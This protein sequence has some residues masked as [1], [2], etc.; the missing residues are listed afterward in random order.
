[1]A[2]VTAETQRWVLLAVMTL[3]EIHELTDFPS[4]QPI[5]RHEMPDILKQ[6]VAREVRMAMLRMAA[7]ARAAEVQEEAAAEGTEEGHALPDHIRRQLK[8]YEPTAEELASEKAQ[9]AKAQAHEA[10]AG[11]AA[12]SFLA[13]GAG[14]QP[15]KRKSK[16]H[17]RF[18]VLFRYQEGFTN[19][20]RRPVYFKDLM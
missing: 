1:M 6:M 9:A 15:V 18:A 19:A 13:S 7:R 14:G 11:A 3:R 8:D 20:V 5:V 16:P 4:G 17:S 10:N 12:W 2:C